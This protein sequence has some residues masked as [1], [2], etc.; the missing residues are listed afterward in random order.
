MS[1]SVLEFVL[2]EQHRWQETSR[3]AGIGYSRVDDLVF[4]PVFLFKVNMCWVSTTAATGV[5][6]T[7]APTVL[8]SLAAQSM[9]GAPCASRPREET[10]GLLDHGFKSILLTSAFQLEC[11]ITDRVYIFHVTIWFLDA[12]SFL[13]LYYH[14]LLC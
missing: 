9:D 2:E 1:T 4:C 10:S 3:D 5:T 13:S 6:D 8:S 7:G 12:F 11:L 14:L